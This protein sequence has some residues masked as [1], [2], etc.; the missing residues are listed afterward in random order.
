MVQATDVAA[1]AAQKV[2]TPA[3]PPRRTGSRLSLAHVITLLAG[4]LAVLLVFSVLRS[5]EATW[6]VAVAGREIR[7]GTTL[8]RS[9]F[10]FTDVNAPAEVRRHLLSPEALEQLRGTIAARTIAAGD[11]VSRSDFRPAAAR[12]R[13]RAMSVP[14]DPAH[15]VGGALAPGDRVDVIR[16]QEIGQAVFVVANAEVLAV[17]Q[18]DSRSIGPAGAWSLTVAVSSRDALRLATAIRGE[19]FEVVR[20]TGSDPVAAGADVGQQPAPG[21]QPGAGGQ[22]GG[23]GQPGS[24]AGSQAGGSGQ[25]GA[26]AGSQ[27]TGTTLSY[28]GTG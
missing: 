14:V 11:L 16:V 22:P 17:N 1:T 10:R 20:S 4:L 25:P 6:R 18:P 2:A 21:G 5:R 7:A 24:G 13:L 19:K 3:P 23:S 15:A 9:A 26:G 8:D 12:A 27:P 28:Q